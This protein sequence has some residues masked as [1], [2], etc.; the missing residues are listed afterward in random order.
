MNARPEADKITL[1][2]GSP[3]A[4]D[5]RHIS[6]QLPG[7][8]LRCVDYAPAITIGQSFAQIVGETAIE[9]VR[10][11]LTSKNINVEKSVHTAGQLAES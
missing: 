1:K 7:S 6:L 4:A 5:E 10:V 11:N 9:S 2:V 8:P 3:F